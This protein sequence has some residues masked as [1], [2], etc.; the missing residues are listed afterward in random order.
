MIKSCRVPF[1]GPSADW[2]VDVKHPD[3]EDVI[4]QAT[5]HMPE[6][7]EIVK[8]HGIR[9]GRVPLELRCYLRER[10]PSSD[11]EAARIAMTA[12]ER[13]ILFTCKNPR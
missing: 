2:A 11:A 12:P 6:P 7:P 1:D 3:P 8:D 5:L 9:G 4:G 10:M 13:G